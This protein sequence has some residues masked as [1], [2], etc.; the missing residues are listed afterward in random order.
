M[1][2]HERPLAQASVRA[3]PFLAALGL[4]LALLAP[5]AIGAGVDSLTTKFVVTFDPESC[6]YEP[7]GKQGHVYIR[8]ADKALNGLPALYPCVSIEPY[9]RRGTAWYEPN[10]PWIIGLLNVTDPDSTINVLRADPRIV[11][12]HVYDMTEGEVITDH[13]ATEFPPDKPRLCDSQVYYHGRA[14][15]ESPFPEESCWYRPPVNHDCDM[16]LPQAWSITKGDSNVVVAIVDTGVDIFH[17]AIGGPGPGYSVPDSMGCYNY[18]VLFRNWLEQPGD[19]NSDGYPGVAGVDDDGDGLI[20]ENS[21]LLQPGN[22]IEADVYS[23]ALTSADSLTVYDASASWITNEHIG[24]YLWGNTQ[25]MM[26]SEVIISNTANS[27]TTAADSILYLIP[28]GWAT[29]T[30][31]SSSYL[32]GNGLDDD[33]DGVIDDYQAYAA[34]LVDDDDENGYP[35][36]MHGWDFWTGP[37]V[38][39]L[40]NEDRGEQDNDVRT[41]SDHGTY[42]ASII[43]T[44]A[45]SPM[46][47]IAPGVRILPIRAGGAYAPMGIHCYAQGVND[48]IIP[49]AFAY[50]QQ[51]GASIVVTAR[52]Y[53]PDYCVLAAE[54][55]ARNGILHVNGAGNTN[56][57]AQHPYSNAE[58]SLLVAGVD[59]TDAKTGES[60]YGSWV[61]VAA[62]GDGIYVA[63]AHLRK[64]GDWEAG[65][66]DYDESAHGTSLS[67]PIVAGV[68]ALIKSAYPH[69]GLQDI[70]NKLLTSVD[71]IY[72][73][74][75]D[76]LLNAAYEDGHQLGSGR[77][78]A[79]KALTFY[80]PVGTVES[81]TTW[82]NTVWVSG[83]IEVPA[84]VTLTV[85][86]GTTIKMAQSDIM[87][88]GQS[89]QRCEIHVRGTLLLQGT[90]QDSIT[91]DIH[92]DDGT[93]HL[94]GPIVF[95]DRAA[96]ARSTLSHTRF[97]HAVDPAYVVPEIA[98]DAVFVN[99]SDD[100]GLSFAGTPYAQVQLDYDG[101]QDKDLFISVKDNAGKLFKNFELFDGVP[102]MRDVTVGAFVADHEPGEAL[103]APSVCDIN[104]D[105]A[106]DLFVAGESGA[107][108]YVNSGAPNWQYTDSLAASGLS[109]YVANSWSGSWADYDGDARADLLICTVPGSGTDPGPDM[110][111]GA[112]YLLKNETWDGDVR[113][114]DVT[115]S[116][117][118]SVPSGALISGTWGD[119]DNDG[120]LDLVLPDER[121][122]S[123]LGT[124]ALWCYL[125]NG[126]STFTRVEMDRFVMWRPDEVQDIAAITLADC[127]NNGA[128]DL[129]V[130]Q[131][132]PWGGGW[133]HFNNGGSYFR[134]RGPAYFD[135]GKTI[136]VRPLDH[137]LDGLVDMLF[138]PHAADQPVRLMLNRSTANPDSAVFFDV[139]SEVQL[140]G[141]RA[142]GAAV[143]DFN[144][145]GDPDV[146]LG[147]PTTSGKFF[148]KT[149]QTG[150]GEA[151]ANGWVGMRLI[152]S[153]ANNEMSLGARVTVQVDTFTQAQVVDGGS[154]R[155]GQI[156]DR[157]VWG[158]GSLSGLI[159]ATTV[160]PNGES[161]L[162]TLTANTYT[163]VHDK[164]SPKVVA[165]TVTGQYIA[166]PG[167]KADWVFEWETEHACRPA[168]DK[169]LISDGS[170]PPQC[171]V[172]GT[173]EL[174][175]SYNGVVASVSPLPGGRYF[176]SLKWEDVDCAA[177]CTYNYRVRSATDYVR[178]TSA[179]KQLKMKVCIQ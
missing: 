104:N 130:A 133:V 55:L 13:G 28:G 157:L 70:R 92:R 41:V 68:A 94:W 101:D 74:P 155:G 19:A 128:L 177:T 24:K 127:D 132:P 33:E 62:R 124:S 118:G 125:S 64:C 38:L 99:R 144:L 166:K 173:L 23:G 172:V 109:S 150:G 102:S 83:D 45:E 140:T 7:S 58:A 61:D 171:P 159:T 146:F 31:G 27:I 85:A 174:D 119:L 137:D 47:S 2:I 5:A 88:R 148:Y 135:I 154:G 175:A 84:G 52:A 60:S 179:Q 158:L 86:A 80:G 17:P 123:G 120:D 97:L 79:Y 176:H 77:V 114:R 67:G 4:L 1:K 71:D 20:D 39:G 113:F 14:S 98:P 105:G 9:H 117:F 90:A 152:P 131:N 160:W 75:Q 167:G 126:D 134:D 72:T 156:D 6:V 165:G 106:A 10:G 76:P 136:D 116:A 95:A 56:T 145:D 44:T 111:T 81:D 34:D 141:E 30:N 170:N 42:L 21:L 115:T 63:R 78:N 107:R 54:T 25:H 36:D 57:T 110:P 37:P 53:A 138:L 168:L 103:R 11:N 69:W 121:V 163:Y 43:A 22:I 59:N 66:H 16:D 151:P 15:W 18:G 153:G 162:D 12:V 91:I 147:R 48:E 3:S 46:A 40:P 96:L 51:M 93:D 26:V 65:E 139:T 50:A 29:V 8:A 142:D 129:C 35:D 164:S 178:S 32:V 149:V 112:L 161:Q 82:T 100:T 143:C 49:Q 89:A 169:V 108:L 87:E 122:F 73:I